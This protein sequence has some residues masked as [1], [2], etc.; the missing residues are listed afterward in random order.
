M[1]GQLTN[2]IVEI[3]SKNMPPLARAHNIKST[4]FSE[5]FW[6]SASAK[7]YLR[8]ILAIDTSKCSSP[9]EEHRACRAVILM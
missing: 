7:S 3:P 4:I 5:I 2:Q 8:R 1:F 6:K 9:E